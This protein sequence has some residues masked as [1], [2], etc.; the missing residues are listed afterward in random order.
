LIKKLYYLSIGWMIFIL[1]GNILDL[2]VTPGTYIG[3]TNA[4]DLVFQ[5]LGLGTIA[6]T[7]FWIT[8]HFYKKSK[9][10]KEH[11]LLKR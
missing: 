9:G 7:P 8:R 3:Y 10:K 6:T 1:L 4:F 2:I 11:T 5:I